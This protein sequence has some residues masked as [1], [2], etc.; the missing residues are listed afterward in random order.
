[1]KSVQHMIKDSKIQN[2]DKSLLEISDRSKQHFKVISDMRRSIFGGFFDN[3][4]LFMYL[5]TLL[6]NADMVYCVNKIIEDNVS[7]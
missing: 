4:I 7:A 1:M 6:E 5:V 3:D 2:P